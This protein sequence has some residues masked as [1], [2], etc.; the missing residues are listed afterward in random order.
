MRPHGLPA[1]HSQVIFSSAI[2]MRHR[3]RNACAKCKKAHNKVAFLALYTIHWDQFSPYRSSSTPQRPVTT[4]SP[5]LGTQDTLQDT[6]AHQIQA[7]LNPSTPPAAQDL[8]VDTPHLHIAGHAQTIEQ[9]VQ[10]D[11]Y[12]TGYNQATGWPLPAENSLPLFFPPNPVGNDQGVL[13]PNLIQSDPP[14]LPNAYMSSASWAY[15]DSQGPDLFS[16]GNFQSMVT[17]LGPTNFS[18]P[19]EY[20]ADDLPF[21][22]DIFP[23]TN[24]DSAM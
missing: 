23:Y 20:P 12:H 7:Q 16:A 13:Y 11:T 3:G 1:T 6:L 21:A 4:P 5:L 18:Y 15:P 10:A 9:S 19:E 22:Y 24:D 14:D 8:W 2:Q 17:Q